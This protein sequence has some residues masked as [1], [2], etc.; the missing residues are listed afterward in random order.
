MKL[1]S[2]LIFGIILLLVIIIILIY[3]DI[4]K[5]NNLLNLILKY[6]SYVI[7]LI[8]L[9]ISIYKNP[10]KSGSNSGI[11]NNK[12][13]NNPYDIVDKNKKFEDISVKELLEINI[14]DT[15]NKIN[16]LNTQLYEKNDNNN[17]LN[18]ELQKYLINTK[19]NN[20]SVDNYYINKIQNQ[21]NDNNENI[22]ILN[23]EIK[24]EEN[25]LNNYQKNYNSYLPTNFNKFLGKIL[26]KK[27]T[28]GHIYGE[29][30]PS[31]GYGQF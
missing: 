8:L 20:I 26:K 31:S 13:I 11:I 17:I 10:C 24:K 27:T 16:E 19:N 14:K 2:I 6:S 23:L 5:Q 28:D 25:K 12:I 7:S 30:P 1:D 22:N 9:L 29:F 21:I 4:T 15:K 18:K 3:L